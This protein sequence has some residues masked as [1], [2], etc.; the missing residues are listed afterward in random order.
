MNILVIGAGAIGC[1]VGGKLAHSGQQVTFGSRPRFVEAVRA[2][3]LVLIDETGR[4]VID[5]AHAAPSIDAAF[6][7]TD[8]PFDL[9]IL[10]VKSYDTATAVAELDAAAKATSQPLPPL[11]S[12]QNGVGN[13]ETIAAKLTCP[14]LAGVITT[15]VSVPAPAVV[16]VDRPSYTLGLSLWGDPPASHSTRRTGSPTD[17]PLY[18]AQ[19]ALRTAGFRV[20]TYPHA[21]GLKWTKLLMNMMGNALS[22][23]LDEPPARLF[24]DPRLADLEIRAW[25]E[26]LHVMARAGIPPVNLGSYP[27]GLLAPL[28]RYAPAAW[29]RPIL[30]P[31]V[32]KARGSKMPSLHMDLH[33]SR[34]RVPSDAPAPPEI[35]ANR[36]TPIR[37]EVEWLNGAVTRKG[38]ELRVPTPVNQLLT[39]T[40]LRL[41]NEPAACADYRH[42]PE[43]LL[44]DLHQAQP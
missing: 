18:R 2:Q 3:G 44:A 14:V 1:L 35:P 24:L 40:L 4:H 27:F 16:Q 6:Q 11:L 15:P 20:R 33:A 21:Q 37:S 13:E 26:A 7:A 22:A 8:R 34:A 10:T 42:Q 12:L 17:T 32:G 23:I 38:R 5:A 41:F 30:K 19:E 29:L 25:R 36:E 43:R 39:D 28:I 9:A 31:Q